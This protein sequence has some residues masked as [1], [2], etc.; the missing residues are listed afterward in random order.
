M[1]LLFNNLQPFLLTYICSCN[2][3][4]LLYLDLLL[5]WNFFFY[6]FTTGTVDLFQFLNWWLILLQAYCH[7]KL[8]LLA[9]FAEKLRIVIF[10]SFRIARFGFQLSEGAFSL[11]N[12]NFS[13]LACSFID[14]NFIFKLSACTHWIDETHGTQNRR[15]EQWTFY[16]GLTL[17]V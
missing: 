3:T 12:S 13:N 2:M 9:Q 16:L 11:F 14:V 6:F 1:Q 17:K 7:I 10:R 5:S 8:F 4:L 15:T